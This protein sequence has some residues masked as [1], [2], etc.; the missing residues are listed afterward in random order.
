MKVPLQFF[1][2]LALMILTSCAVSPDR[3]LPDLGMTIPAAWAT[4][5][6][7]RDDIRVG[8]LAD[9]DDV[10][11][12]ELAA[13][14]LRNNFDLQATVARLDQAMEDA[15]IAGADQLPSVDLSAS[16]SKAQSLSRTPAGAADTF[17]GF[18]R[19]RSTTLGLSMDV[20]WELDVWG[21]IR[22]NKAAAL[23]DVEGAM[24]DL[25]AA[26]LSLVAQTAKAWFALTDAKLQKDLAEETAKSRKETTELLHSRFKNGITEAL[27]V[28]LARSSEAEALALVEEVTINFEQAQRALEI[29]LGRYPG[30]ELVAAEDLQAVPP[31]IPAGIPA[32]ILTRRPDLAAAERRVAAALMRKKSAKAAKYPRISLTASAGTTSDALSDLVDPKQN[33]WNFAMNFLTPVFDAGRLAAEE[34]KADAR[35]R[36]LVADFG[37]QALT[38]FEEVET[39]LSNEEKLKKSE[40]NL[41]VARDELLAAYNQA[42]ESYQQGLVDILTVLDTERRMLAARQDY[43]TIRRRRLQSR[44]DLHLALGGNFEARLV[45]Q[46]QESAL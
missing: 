33:I 2:S 16:G 36:E 8:W 14:M 12:L 3:R 27:D 11:L 13:E 42:T 39:A 19:S 23:A 17:D 32:Q 38:A 29:L 45:Q 21:R 24:D 43:I 20:S 15:V 1:L 6:V 5:E 37:T 40:E 34:K 41:K 30:A 35:Q 46:K 10:I 22:S 18:S 4:T 44:V 31:P 9:F 25:Q 7:M 26:R 28:H